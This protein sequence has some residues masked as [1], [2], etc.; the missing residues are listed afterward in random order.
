MSWLIPGYVYRLY[1]YT[2]SLS[3]EQFD[4][5]DSR[6][7]DSVALL[8]TLALGHLFNFNKNTVYKMHVHTKCKA[9]MTAARLHLMYI[10]IMQ[11]I[12]NSKIV[13]DT[14]ENNS[15]A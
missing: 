12:T 10:I 1:V 15:A 2:E 3:V 8:L 7:N 4:F 5:Y 14:T 13:H 11:I 9:R 6:L